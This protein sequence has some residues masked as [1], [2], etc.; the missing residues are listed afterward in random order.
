MSIWDYIRRRIAPKPSP[1][2]TP[3]TPP[4]PPPIDPEVAR[5]RAE[6]MRRRAADGLRFKKFQSEA[7]ST[8][9]LP[10]AP[11]SI[12][13]Y[14]NHPEYVWNPYEPNPEKPEPVVFPK[15]TYTIFVNTKP[16]SKITV[17]KDTAQSIVQ[18][19][20]MNDELVKKELANKSVQK[21]VFTEDSITFVVSDLTAPKARYDADFLEY[22]RLKLKMPAW[23]MVYP[24]PTVGY[25]ITHPDYV[26]DYRVR[27]PQ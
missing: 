27:T 3:I 20:A 12:D 17:L 5:K 22:R 7:M 25:Y 18:M 11:P 15:T 24:P 2:P 13:W 9:F 21:T 8:G 6:A 14:V 16:V 4:T 10:P 1:A 19:H 26:W 23:V